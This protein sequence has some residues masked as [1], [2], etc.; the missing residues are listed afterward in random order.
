MYEEGHAVAQFAEAT[1][2]EVAG[3]IPDGI[4]TIFYRHNYSGRIMALGLTQ[5]AIEMG[6]R[7]I[8]WG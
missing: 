1:S 4:I 8:F 7:D 3:S 6:T 2:R 5:H